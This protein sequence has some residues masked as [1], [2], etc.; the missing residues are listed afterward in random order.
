MGHM[1]HM[2][3]EW[4]E[5]NQ[6][7][8][9]SS[10]GMVGSRRRGGLK[11]LRPRLKRKGYVHVCIYGDGKHI[12]RTIHTLVAEAFLGPKP[13][14]AHQINHKNGIRSDNRVSNLEW[15]TQSENQR[16]RYYVLKHAGLHGEANG[17]AKL[18]AG[19]VLEIRARLSAG[20]PQRRLSAA[21]G[22]GQSQIS[23]IARGTSWASVTQ[24]VTA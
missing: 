8:I 16:H 1:E 6:D 10:D 7:Y 15:V 22:V 23:R 11:M 17:N 21:Y 9:V 18:T 12:D 14:P 19:N 20:E 4:R 3:I 13:T 24:E 2:A 5:I